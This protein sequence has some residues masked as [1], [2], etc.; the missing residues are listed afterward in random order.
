MSKTAEK[1][2][3]DKGSAEFQAMFDKAQN[4]HPDKMEFSPDESQKFRKAFDDPEFRKLFS[5]YMDDLQDPNHRAETETY[6]SQLEKE[7]KVPNGKELVRP[8]PVFVAKTKKV[9]SDGMG[10]KIFMNIVQS[11]KISP[12]TSTKSAEGTNWSL[13]Y[14]LGPPHMEK[15]KNDSNATCFDCCFHP[16]AIKLGQNHKKVF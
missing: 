5:Q 8:D 7:D 3:E 15:D 16:E 1:I 10:D 14:S 12:P 9:V 6:I 11:D 4:E 13:P 2:F